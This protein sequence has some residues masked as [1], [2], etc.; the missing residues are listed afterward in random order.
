MYTVTGTAAQERLYRQGNIETLEDVESVMDTMAASFQA[1]DFTYGRPA[2]QGWKP[3]QLCLTVI[4]RGG[5]M[6]GYR[7]IKR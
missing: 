1:G 7:N 5:G 6:I 3:E 2:A 4:L